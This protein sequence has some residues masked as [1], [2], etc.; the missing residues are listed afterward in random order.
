MWPLSYLLNPARRSKEREMNRALTLIND[1]VAII[2]TDPD[3]INIPY[4]A[5][6]QTR[7]ILTWLAAGHTLSSWILITQL[8][9]TS[10]AARGREVRKWLRANGFKLVEKTKKV[11][12]VPV[13][14]FQL[15]ACD[16]PRLRA[17]LQSKESK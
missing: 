3:A 6:S 13:L 1:R 4:K 11:D 12:G 15:A 17:M 5:K 14:F 9:A 2:R 10:G 16:R 8:R 7:R